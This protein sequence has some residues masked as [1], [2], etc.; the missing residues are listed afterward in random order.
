MNGESP[1]SV[2]SA[3]EKKP[4]Q[5]LRGH[6]VQLKMAETELAPAVNVEA[7]EQLVPMHSKADEEAVF[8]VTTITSPSTSFETTAEIPTNVDT[9]EN[10]PFIAAPEDVKEP[11]GSVLSTST[12]PE[13]NLD[14]E[15][16]DDD[17]ATF[18]SNALK[19]II[20]NVAESAPEIVEPVRTS[21]STEHSTSAATT[22][23]EEATEESVTVPTEPTPTTPYDPIAFYV[24]PKPSRP[25]K[26][27]KSEQ[28]LSKL[29]V[30]KL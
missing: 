17:D 23:S 24:R 29:E 6:R 4:S 22:I 25:A 9:A 3:S 7:M 14:D 20:G 21:S 28:N 13:V 10:P 2:W 5:K 1:A 19:Q 11:I 27:E 12:E 18:N 8:D 30:Y 16:E 15:E 26:K